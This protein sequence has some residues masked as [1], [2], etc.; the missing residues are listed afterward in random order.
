MWNLQKGCVQYAPE[1]LPGEISW[2]QQ[3]GQV[4]QRILTS[5]P[6]V[7]F[8]LDVSWKLCHSSSLGKEPSVPAFHQPGEGHTGQGGGPAARMPRAFTSSRLLSAKGKCP[9]TRQHVLSWRSTKGSLGCSVIQR[10]D[11]LQ[12]NHRHR[13]GQSFRQKYASKAHRI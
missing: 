9:I 8:S 11:P 5:H 6:S 10:T 12:I 7:T 13:A 3:R 1:L 2:L 4:S